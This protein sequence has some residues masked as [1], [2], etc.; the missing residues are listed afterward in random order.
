MNDNTV[1]LISNIVFRDEA[2]SGY[3]QCVNEKI[4]RKKTQ[5]ETF[6]KNFLNLYQPGIEE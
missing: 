2:A 3:V 4:Y 5:W 6:K 1:L